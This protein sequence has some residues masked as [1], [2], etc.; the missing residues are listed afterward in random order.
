MN[1]IDITIFYL[2]DRS[3]FYEN[4]G[5]FVKYIGSINCRDVPKVIKTF[6]DKNIKCL[7]QIDYC[8]YTIFNKIQ[9]EIIKNEIN[10]DD[11][12]KILLQSTINLINKAIKIIEKEKKNCYLVLEGE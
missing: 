1:R 12:K 11:T 8:G 6:R 3:I 10:K 7:N 4:I 5:K 9:I 2:L